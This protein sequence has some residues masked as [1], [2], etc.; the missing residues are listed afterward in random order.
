MGIPRRAVAVLLRAIDFQEGDRVDEALLL[1]LI[2]GAV[3]GN[4]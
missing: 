1:D 4:K 3:A 2:R